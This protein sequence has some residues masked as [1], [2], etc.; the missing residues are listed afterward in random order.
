MSKEERINFGLIGCGSM[1]AYLSERFNG[2]EEGSIVAVSDIDPTMGKSLAAKIEADY[3]P[4]LDELLGRKDLKAVIVAA[5]NHLHADLTIKAASAGKH[6][7]C[8]K[9][10]ALSLADCDRMMQAANKNGVKLMVGH[11]LRLFPTFTKIKEIIDEGAIGKISSI[12]MR[13]LAKLDLESSWRRDKGLSGGGLFEVSIHEL[14]YM[15]Y[16]AGEV[17]EVYSLMNGHRPGEINYEGSAL[18]TLRFANGAI[19]DLNSSTVSSINIYD[20]VIQGDRG[21]LFLNKTEGSINYVST[22]G[23]EKEIGIKDIKGEDPYRAELRN[24]IHSILKGERLLFDG[25][26][27]RKVVEIVEAAFMSQSTRAPVKLPL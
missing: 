19:G 6:V 5:P 17:E 27:G 9:P 15:R 21:T 16:L 22:D 13:R 24:F 7:F 2:L 8:E 20:G 23:T 3:V 25:E 1:G 11:V 4:D 26:D 12:S 14:D 18:V 10:M